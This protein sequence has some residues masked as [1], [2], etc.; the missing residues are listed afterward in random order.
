MSLL[1]YNELKALVDSGAIENVHPDQINGASIDVTLADGYLVEDRPYGCRE[2]VRIADKETPKMIKASG[3][4]VLKPGDFALA[5]TEQIFHLPNDITAIYV[6]KS[7]MARAGL[8][9][10]NAGFADPTW[11]G[12]AL[13]LEFKNELR[14][15]TLVLTPGQ[16]CGQMYFHRG[17]PVPQ[18]K[19]YAVRGQYCGDRGVQAS[20][21]VR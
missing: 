1:T 21:G 6:L 10:L 4:L 18:E 15:H 19:S 12:S 11:N 16:K 2:Y 17:Q 14:Y 9:H 13:T 3:D 8:N 20:K 7:S 5:A